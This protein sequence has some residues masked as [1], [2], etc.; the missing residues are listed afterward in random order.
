MAKEKKTTKKKDTTEAKVVTA[1]DR[2]KQ[3]E[4]ELWKAACKL[5]T[6]TQ[7]KPSDYK[8]PV[9]ALI[10]L[11]FADQKFQKVSKELE[12]GSSR[13]REPGPNDYKAR[14]CVYLAPE[15]RWD[16]LKSLP[17][18]ENVG[19]AVNKAMDLIME[20][21]E[22]LKGVMPK[23]FNR[24]QSAILLDLM[25]VFNPSEGLE[26]DTFGRIYEFFM[27]EFE[28]DS[29][30]KGGEFFTPPSLVNL[31]TEIIE[32]YHGKIYDP[33]C[34][35]GGMF[36][37][38][39]KFVE[40]HKKRPSEELAAFGQERIAE[41][42]RIGKMNLAINGF[43]GSIKDANSYYQD[44]HNATGKF[45]FVMA[46]PPFNASG[47]DYDRIKD[48]KKRFPFGMPSVDNGNYLW[49]QLFYSALNQNGRAGFVMA[50]SASDARNSEMEIRKKIIQSGAVDVMVSIGTNFFYT[51]TLPC[52][53]WFFD[54]GKPAERKDKI[55]FI[56]ARDVFTQVTRAV[57]EY[58]TEQMEFLANIVRLY[59]GE[60]LE[61]SF[62]NALFKAA[63]PDGKYV[64]IKGRCKVA[65][66]EEVEKQG[67]SLNPGRYVGA[68]DK[69][70]DEKDFTERMNEL[71]SEFIQLNAN[72]SELSK[73]IITVF[74]R[75]SI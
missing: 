32:P 75:L 68:Q 27:S 70:V 42:I 31:I 47:I 11:R 35:S 62:E 38:S 74:E 36:V 20:H 34:G 30:Q 49:I 9:L 26:G 71:R 39:A 60:K 46:N 8:I 67:W 65:T 7:L 4:N 33:A 13:R 44:E 28:K 43:S 12:G 2:L 21:N 73:S 37:S 48:D 55:L 41:T 64:D 17:E 29:G 19:A 1:S 23:T 51:V 54:K 50:N 66:I 18:R 5:W 57:R 24:F 56:D 10:F 45:D 40:A 3:F 22:D 14:G 58:S 52:S 6:G 69:Q 59:R 72:G 16:F 53:L 61:F 63:F 25:R 15:A